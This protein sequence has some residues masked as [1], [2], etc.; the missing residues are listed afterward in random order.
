MKFNKKIP[1]FDNEKE[2]MNQLHGHFLFYK[3]RKKPVEREILK[4]LAILL[5]SNE[6]FSLPSDFSQYIPIVKLDYGYKNRKKSNYIVQ[7]KIKGIQYIILNS[8]NSDLIKKIIILSKNKKYNF[9]EIKSISL[10]FYKYKNDWIFPDHGWFFTTNDFYCVNFLENKIS[11]EE[12]LK[13]YKKISK[14][15]ILEIILFFNNEKIETQ[16]RIKNN[17]EI[18]NVPNLFYEKEKPNYKKETINKINEN[19]SNDKR[20]LEELA[21]DVLK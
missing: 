15:K 20:I 13:K 19:I 8:N 4:T 7:F 21:K 10:M 1:F 12:V 17:I 9:K 3:R 18:D 6:K 14:E 11:R 16:K 2:I 5:E